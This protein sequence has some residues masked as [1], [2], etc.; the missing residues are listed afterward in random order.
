MFLDFYLSNFYELTMFFIFVSTMIYFIS[1]AIY[2]VIKK[3]DNYNVV[4]L[5]LISISISFILNSCLIYCQYN[6]EIY[7]NNLKT[8]IKIEKDIYSNDGSK[9][10]LSKKWSEKELEYIKEL[11]SQTKE[12]PYVKEGKY[13]VLINKLEEYKEKYRKIEAKNTDNSKNEKAE[14]MKE[15]LHR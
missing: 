5:G 8:L 10:F 12:D 9:E 7:L 15:Y 13:E 14:L 6:K 1:G 4:I 3:N 2:M 11:I